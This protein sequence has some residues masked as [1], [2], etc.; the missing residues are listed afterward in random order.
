MRC[1]LSWDM[2]EAKQTNKNPQQLE[3]EHAR[4]K[5]P[6]KQRDKESK[7]LVDATNGVW[8]VS[9]DCVVSERGNG[10]RRA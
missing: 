6:Q 10:V 9:L 8:P 2:K 4:Q 1:H 3:E 5:D 7:L